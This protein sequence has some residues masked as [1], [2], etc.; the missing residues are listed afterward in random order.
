MEEETVPVTNWDCF[1]ISWLLLQEDKD[2][3]RGSWNSLPVMV[4]LATPAHLAEEE[5][6]YTCWVRKSWSNLLQWIVKK[7]TL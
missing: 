1:S 3:Y 6:A 5:F 7:K 4:G 2:I